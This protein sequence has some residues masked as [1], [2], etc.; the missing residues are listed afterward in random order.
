VTQAVVLVEVPSSTGKCYVCFSQK[1]V[2]PAVSRLVLLVLEGSGSTAS[3][4]PGR[5]VPSAGSCSGTTATSTSTTGLAETCFFSTP[6]Q[7]RRIATHTKPK[8]LST[9]PN[10][11]YSFD[12][13]YFDLEVFNENTVY[14]QIFK[15]TMQ[16]VK[17]ILVLLSNTKNHM[18]R[19]CSFNLPFL[20]FDD[21]IRICNIVH[22]IMIRPK[23]AKYDGAPPRCV[24]NRNMHLNKMHTIQETKLLLDFTNQAHMQHKDI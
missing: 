11:D 2:S 23:F 17:Y 21:N 10:D 1:A 20:V 7:P 14:L 24:H 15:A 4:V 13:D 19:L 12:L 6:L 8:N 18:V 5:R 16:T 22:D 3:E 9:M